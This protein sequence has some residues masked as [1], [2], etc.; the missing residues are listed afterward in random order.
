MTTVD[1]TFV[2]RASSHI[3]EFSYEPDVENLTVTFQSGDAYTYFNVPVSV[4]RAWSAEGGSGRFF[5]RQIKNHYSY[6]QQ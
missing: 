4:Y 5:A 2:P 6:E 3:A 1:E